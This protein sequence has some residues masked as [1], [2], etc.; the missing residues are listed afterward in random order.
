MSAWWLLVLLVVGM[1]VWESAILAA[2][3]V[4]AG[5]VVGIVVSVPMG[6]PAVPVAGWLW[7]AGSALLVV[8][9]A[10]TLP[11]LRLL[12]VRPITGVALR[13]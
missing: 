1:V 13:T 8:V 11:L 12:A 4:A 6:L 10:A 7:V 2:G 3:A 9:A 5:A